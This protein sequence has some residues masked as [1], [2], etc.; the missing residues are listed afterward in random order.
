MTK[1]PPPGEAST[2]SA[3]Q[4]IH[5]PAITASK[6]LP[7]SRSTSAAASAV[8]SWPAATA[9][10]LPLVAMVPGDGVRTGQPA[11]RGYSAAAWITGAA[12]RTSGST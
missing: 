1:P 8:S 2:G 3:T 7:P 5:R 4:A 10:L 9:P 6:A 12:S 11:R